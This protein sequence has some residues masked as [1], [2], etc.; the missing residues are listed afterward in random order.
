MTREEPWRSSTRTRKGT[1]VEFMRSSRRPGN[2]AAH[3]EEQDADVVA[4]SP[5]GGDHQWL[6]RRCVDVSATSNA[7]PHEANP[8]GYA[9]NGKTRRRGRADSHAGRHMFQHVREFR[10]VSPRRSNQVGIAETTRCRS[11]RDGE[12]GAE[13]PYIY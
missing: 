12:R 7:R 1:G 8:A 5:P 4:R 3:N 13:S 6:R 9:V 2:L 11:P 10:E